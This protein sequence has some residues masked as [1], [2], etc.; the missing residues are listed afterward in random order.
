MTGTAMTEAAEFWKIY[1][2]DVIAIPTNKPLQRINNPDVIYR[3]EREKFTAIADEIE[4]MH[5]WDV[6][7]IRQ[8]RGVPGHDRPRDRR[9]DRVP[10]QGQQGPRDHRQAQDQARS[11]AAGGRSWS[12]PCR[13]SGAS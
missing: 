10:A 4:R 12:A 6:L 13:S 3:T 5:K 9:H 2:L 8:G 7:L 1:K 11:S